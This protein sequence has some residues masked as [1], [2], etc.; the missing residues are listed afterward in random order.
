MATK[1]FEGIK[2]FFLMGFMIASVGLIL[3][4]WADGLIDQE[5]EKP[6][7]YRE[8]MEIDAS[9][10]A[11]MT[12]VAKNYELGTGTPVREHKNQASQDKQTATPGYTPT[13]KPTTD[14][15]AAEQDQ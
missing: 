1:K 6:S 9:V 8:T 5:P 7:Y 14:W 3:L 12:A 2:K 11:T 13:P 4:M 10:Y 15:D